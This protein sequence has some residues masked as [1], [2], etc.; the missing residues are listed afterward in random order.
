MGSQQEIS[1]QD[2]AKLVKKEL[3]Q[4]SSDIVYVPYDQAYAEGFEDMQ[5]RVPDVEQAGITGGVCAPNRS[6]RKKVVLPS[7]V[8]DAVF[9][10]GVDLS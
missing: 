10:P 6:H 1:I 4:S 9:P 8:I 3:T 5:R 2:L 7:K